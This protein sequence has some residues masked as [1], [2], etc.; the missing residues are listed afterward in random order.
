MG[1]PRSA[2]QCVK[3]THIEGGLANMR[4]VIEGGDS[5]CLLWKIPTERR[6]ESK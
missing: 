5:G 2:S 4:K 1:Q 3:E 6:A